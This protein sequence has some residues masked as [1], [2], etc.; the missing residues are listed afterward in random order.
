MKTKTIKSKSLK[1]E[2][3]LIFQIETL[4]E[5]LHT[6]FSNKTKELLVE[7]RIEKLAE[8]KVKAPDIYNE[9]LQII[10]GNKKAH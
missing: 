1:I 2:E 10:S 8:L 3:D 7:W 6:N 5:L 9:Y 4:C